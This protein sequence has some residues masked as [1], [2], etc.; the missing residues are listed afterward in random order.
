MPLLK[1]G[2]RQATP[3]RGKLHSEP[4][5][6]EKN[7]RDRMRDLNRERGENEGK[8]DIAK[9]IPEAEKRGGKA[10]KEVAVHS[11]DQPNYVSYF[12]FPRIIFLPLSLNY[13]FSHSLLSS[14]FRFTSC[15]TGKRW[16]AKLVLYF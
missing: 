16:N 14:L 13:P 15:Y 1:S 6:G 9:G 11:I 10:R 3:A 8:R 5:S 12:G 7:G 4:N 2:Y